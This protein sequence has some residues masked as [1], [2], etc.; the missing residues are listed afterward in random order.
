[1]IQE[2]LSQ[3]QQHLGRILAMAMLALSLALT[4]AAGAVGYYNVGYTAQRLAAERQSAAEATGLG[5]ADGAGGEVEP[6][7]ALPE[8][9]RP[10]WIQAC[11]K[12]LSMVSPGL[13]AFTGLLMAWGALLLLRLPA[14]TTRIAGSRFPFPTRYKPYY[15]NMG[16]LGT[17][18]GFVIAFS[19]INP[20]A[21]GQSTVLLDALGTALWSTLTAIFLAY[22]FCPL[23]EVAYQKIGRL[24]F[25]YMP[26]SDPR[27]QIQRLQQRADDAVAAFE[28]LAG[29]ADSLAGEL[30]RESWALRL[31]EA[32]SHL[33][34]LLKRLIPLEQR[35]ADLHDASRKLN[36]TV[37]KLS[38]DSELASERLEARI[39]RLERRTE[40]R[41]EELERRVEA[42]LGG[43]RK[44]LA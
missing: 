32:E 25:G 28:R 15:V 39:E 6:A 30:D 13:V 7:A 36:E 12:D 41:A 10:A 20:R 8:T 26:D 19:D 17:I 33:A 1:M 27:S 18:V 31:T 2:I 23:I 9:Q 42:L 35:V 29:S 38:T 5:S 21:E 44:A 14:P 3:R 34:T 22:L 40:G 4:A 37:A 24:R 16:L 11:L 43:F